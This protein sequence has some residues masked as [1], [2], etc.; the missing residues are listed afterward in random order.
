MAKKLDVA[1]LAF[2]EGY[3]MIVN[4]FIMDLRETNP[5]IKVVLISQNDRASDNLADLVTNV[6]EVC[7][8]HA[9]ATVNKIENVL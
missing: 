2:Y 9:S 4:Q 5:A 7:F 8:N 3:E 1:I 6:T